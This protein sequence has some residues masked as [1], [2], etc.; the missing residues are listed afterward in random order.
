MLGK[1]ATEIGIP[2]K[3]IDT[4]HSF[5]IATYIDGNI[6]GVKG[7]ADLLFDD[8]SEGKDD[9]LAEKLWI[10]TKELNYDECKILLSEKFGEPLGEVEIPYAQVNY[11]ALTRADFRFQDYVIELSTASELDHISIKIEKYV[12]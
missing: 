1:T 4:E 7:Y 8:L 6:F 2:R 9:Y 3:A 12:D 5:Y 11:G 10:Y